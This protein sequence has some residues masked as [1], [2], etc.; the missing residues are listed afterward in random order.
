MMEE[1]GCLELS[2]GALVA[3]RVSCGADGEDKLVPRGAGPM[4]VP[5]QALSP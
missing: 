5:T 1:P 2:P 4:L 3:P